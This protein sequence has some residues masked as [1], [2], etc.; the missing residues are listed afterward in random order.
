MGAVFY[1]PLVGPPERLILF[2]FLILFRCPVAQQC[3]P[4]FFI[5]FK[6]VFLKLN[7]N[8]KF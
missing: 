8:S 4:G 2:F 3:A 5:V 6:L 1:L 7:Q